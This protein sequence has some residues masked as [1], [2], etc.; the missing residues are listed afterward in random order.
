MSSEEVLATDKT[1][2]N[3]SGEKTIRVVLT[4][5]DTPAIK[6]LMREVSKELMKKNEN[7]YRRLAEK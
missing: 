3:K 1:T 4:S 7:L 5:R 2:K 6:E